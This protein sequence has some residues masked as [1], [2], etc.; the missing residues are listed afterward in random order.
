MTQKHNQ[1][2][3]DSTFDE[4]TQENIEEFKD[5]FSTSTGHTKDCINETVEAMKG[6][7]VKVC[8]DKQADLQGVL[9]SI[10]TEAFDNHLREILAGKKCN[11][12]RTKYLS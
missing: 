7:I 12:G 6:L 1:V 4:I 2:D 11:C 10:G 9:D 8:R 5:K 3:K